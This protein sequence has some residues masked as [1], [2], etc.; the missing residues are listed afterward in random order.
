MKASKIFRSISVAIVTMIFPVLLSAQWSA[1]R[2]DHANAFNK[3]FAVTAD[4]AFVTGTEPMT[5]Q[6]FM[7][8]TSDGGNSW[9]SIW[10]NPVSTTYQLMELYFADINNGFSGG[11]KNNTNQLVIKTTDN[12]TTWTEIT[13]DPSSTNAITGIH[14][15]DGQQGFVTNGLCLYSTINGG[16]SWTT[17]TLPFFAE[18][19][20]FTSMTDGFACGSELT[21]SNAVLMKTTD[22]GQTWTQL[23]SAFD[24]STFVS[25]FGKMDFVSSQIAYTSM[26][27]TN[28]LYRTTDGGATWNM[29]V[30][31][32]V[33]TILDFDFS[34]SDTCHVLS[35]MG[36]IFASDDATAN[37]HLE[38][39]TE[40]GFYGPS[41]FLYSIF[42]IGETGYTC[43]TSGLIKKHEV[44]LALPENSV[45]TNNLGIY[46]NP[47]SPG[48]NLV[49]DASGI[50]GICTVTISDIN[51][52]TVFTQEVFADGNSTLI[53]AGLLVANG[54]YV[55]TVSNDSAVKRQK[56]IVAE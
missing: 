32:S 3:V 50:N 31:D 40:W 53:V 25:S 34:S 36:Q 43:G 47:V 21:G 19:I 37:W 45:A 12:G 15:L 5:G 41:V 29:V 13:P 17:D 52:K 49:V 16:T 54:T 24:A 30:V 6:Y 39:A 2:Y 56:L 48:Q 23:L 33:Q 26:Q 1:V 18:H 22:G 20:T 11:F 51:G 28:K 42:F 9:D 10:I 35:G 7:L 4:D 46:P 55:V 38:Y 44:A 14:F 8:R 27:Y